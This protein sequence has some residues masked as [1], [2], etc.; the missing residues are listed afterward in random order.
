[1]VNTLTEMVTR[2]EAATKAKSE[3]LARMSHEIRTP[4]NGIIGMT[5]LAMRDNPDAK[6]MGYLRR[7]DNAA[8]TLLGVINDILDFSKMEAEK[9]EINNTNF[10][11]LRIL[12]SMYDVLSVKSEEKGIAL[13]FSMSNDVPDII[14]SDSLR[15]AQVCLNLCSNAVKF[16]ESGGGIPERVSEIL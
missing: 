6:Q 7:I 16:T 3:F 11:I 12:W 8:K 1:M 5:Y 15:L 13:D 9:M 4:M 2:S 14:I 10:R